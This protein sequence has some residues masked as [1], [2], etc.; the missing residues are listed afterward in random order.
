MDKLGDFFTNRISSL[1]ERIKNMSKM[2]RHKFKCGT[3]YCNGG[4]FLKGLNRFLQ[5]DD[6]NCVV[7]L[8]LRNNCVQHLSRKS[9]H[10]LIILC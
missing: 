8:S 1:Y 2:H 4:L 9:F 3:D 6:F 10:T 7:C 5:Q